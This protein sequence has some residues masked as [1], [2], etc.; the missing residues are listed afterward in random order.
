MAGGFICL[1]CLIVNG[2][3]GSRTGFCCNF[4][5]VALFARRSGSG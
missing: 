2:F 5:E 4:S 1:V 3:A